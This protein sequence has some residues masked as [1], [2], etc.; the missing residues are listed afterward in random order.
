MGESKDSRTP[1]A[2]LSTNH[3]SISRR[4]GSLWHLTGNNSHNKRQANTD[5]ILNVLCKRKKSDTKT[6]YY[7]I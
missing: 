6:M 2:T 3:H 1:A 7:I 5:E 4:N